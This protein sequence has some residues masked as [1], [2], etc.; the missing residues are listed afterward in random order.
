MT[1]RN[2]QK[3]NDLCVCGSSKK[4]KKCCKFIITSKS[5]EETDNQNIKELINKSK[6]YLQGKNIKF[7]K[8]KNTNIIEL[9]FPDK[10]AI[11]SILEHN[12]WNELKRSIDKKIRNTKEEECPICYTDEIKNK[13]VSCN[14]CSNSYCVKC[15]VNIFISNKG[16]VICPFCKYTIGDIMPD[17]MIK[18]G[19]IDILSRAGYR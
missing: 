8:N 1:V 3:A 9:H 2:K 6:E 11:L 19:A 16:L 14:K 13:S 18:L 5:D 17:Y 15:Y 12:T 4:Y 7:E 10:K